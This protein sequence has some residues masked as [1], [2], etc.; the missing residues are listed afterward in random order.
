M[1]F[2][3]ATCDPVLLSLASSGD[4]ADRWTMQGDKVV[5][6]T[7]VSVSVD[8]SAPAAPTFTVTDGEEEGTV[9]ITGSAQD[10]LLIILTYE[11]DYEEENEQGEPETYT[12]R[13]IAA[14]FNP[15]EDGN[16]NVTLR[17]PQ[18][19][20]RISAMSVNAAGGMSDGA[21]G[22]VSGYEATQEQE[23]KTADSF[24]AVKAE[25]IAGRSDV[26]VSVSGA[27][28]MGL[29]VTGE[30]LYRVTEN[31]PAETF[32]ADG[33]DLTGWTNAGAATKFTV[34]NVANGQFVEVVQITRENTYTHD[35]TGTP[36]VSGEKI[37]V[38]RY[39]FAEAGMEAVPSYTVSGAVIAADA[40]TD[41]S[42][43]KFVLTDSADPTV[44]YTATAQITDGTATY[45]FTNVLP[46]TYVLSLD[47][48]VRKLT[49]D[50]AI[51]TVAQA[52][53][54]KDV[55][56]ACAHASTTA[57]PAA[58]S[59]CSTQGH[60]AYT[61]CNDCGKVIAGSDAL[62]PL[63]PSNHE[64]ETELRNAKAA[65]CTETGYTGDTYC[66]ACS[67]KI[68]SGREIPMLAHTE[69]DW[70]V[71]MEP[72]P[73]VEGH[74]HK[75]C[76]VCHAILAEENIE[77][78]PA[79]EPGDL[80][81]DGVFTQGD[82]DAMQTLLETDG[83]EPAADLNGDGVVNIL[84]MVRL[85]GMV[86]DATPKDPGDLDADGTLDEGDIVLME[87][88]LKTDRYVKDADINGDGVINILDLICLQN[89]IAATNPKEKGDL[90]GN[91]VL[92]TAD[93]DAMQAL[94]ATGE[95]SKT[96]DMNDDG[97]VN[98]LDMVRLLRIF[99]DA[100]SRI[101]ADLDG[102]GQLTEEDLDR[103]K[104]VLMNGGDAD[105]NGDGVTD[106]LDLTCMKRLMADSIS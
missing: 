58:A 45:T 33:F 10:A 80:D 62:L 36:V 8:L 29:T 79:Y 72:A 78:L 49:A 4:D 28:T 35:E 23:E 105:I 65:T 61:V 57:V 106:I 24:T 97:V 95:Y 89:M 37:T 103:M 63:D 17:K 100:A 92:D 38:L 55:T 83:Y 90:D 46:G 18:L 91:G 69:S 56:V 19:N 25:Q 75:E 20:A 84:D 14:I 40:R 85:K 48:T 7:T 99:S 52:N 13:N 101:A 98:I 1:Y 50:S 41:V 2:D 59:T 88:L 34:K 27:H 54:T 81:N 102:D 32:P 42:A 5:Y 6:T 66:L 51:V 16:F 70:I 3:A 43:A 31:R 73:G 11:N 94:M 68:A 15:D 60:G 53:I 76:T 82:L 77:A 74:K 67:Q 96:A 47:G 86:Y 9:Q 104:D 39:G 21:T 30:V 64:G 93:L 26:T 22:E 12:E 71:D 44:V 87:N